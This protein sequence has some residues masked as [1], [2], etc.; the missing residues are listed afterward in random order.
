MKTF[1]IGDI[2]G[3]AK[4][5]SQCLERSDF[6]NEEDA[7][8]QLGDVAD[9]WSETS[10]CVEILLS[11]KNLISIRGNHDVW[12]H[13]W[14]KY[15]HTP[16]IWTEQGGR[17]TIDS[18]VKSGLLIE[19]KHKD[20][21]NNQ[22]DWHIDNENRIFIHAGWDYLHPQGFE[23]QASLP[24]NAGTIAKECHWDRS[25]FQGAASAFWGDNKN[26]PFK[27]SRFKAIEQFKEVYIGH[28][29]HQLNKPLWLGNLCNMDTGAGWHGVLC[30]QDINSKEYWISDKSKEL[31]PND[32]GRG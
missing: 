29:A 30:I 22:K 19:Q 6:N 20:F 31:Y 9:G 26:T 5:L 8:I 25:I 15:G 24:V 11:I 17:A 18:Y 28:T 21:W 10:E 4:G 7:L 13:D 14:F 2:H 32:K 16:M 1:V 27:N 3:S 12:C 23:K